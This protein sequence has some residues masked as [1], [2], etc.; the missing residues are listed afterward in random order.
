MSA[1]EQQLAPHARRFTYRT[2]AG[3]DAEVYAAE[4]TFEQAH[5]V[6]RTAGGAIVLAEDNA[7]VSRLTEHADPGA[8]RTLD[9]YPASRRH[10][11]GA[12]R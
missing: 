4:V 12:D 3:R 9:G 1:E 8:P 10:Q 2:W 5:V 11:P 7:N 6:F